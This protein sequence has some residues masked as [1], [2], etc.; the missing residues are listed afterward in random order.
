M[1][2]SDFTLANAKD[3]FGLTLNESQNLFRNLVG[4]QPSDLL[5]RVLEKI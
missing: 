4:V 5:G 2:Y 3:A 1:A